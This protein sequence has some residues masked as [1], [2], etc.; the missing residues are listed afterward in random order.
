MN[1]KTVFKLCLGTADDKK[2]D[3]VF[4]L[5]GHDSSLVYEKGKR[6]I[7]K[8]GYLYAFLDQGSMLDW[9]LE[10]IGQANFKPILLRAMEFGYNLCLMRGRTSRIVSRYHSSIRNLAPVQLRNPDMLNEFW[11]TD[12]TDLSKVIDIFP[13]P[14]G[15]ILIVDFIPDDLLNIIRV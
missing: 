6:S 5:Y 14:K 13:E 11:R 10:F 2:W 4:S 15:S 1:T 8:I 9:I 7:P 3:K 12:K